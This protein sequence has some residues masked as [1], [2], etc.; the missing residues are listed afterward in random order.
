MK[1]SVLS[2]LALAPIQWLR[3]IRGFRLVYTPPC[4]LLFYLPPS[5]G[6]FWEP[7]TCEKG[8]QEA[9]LFRELSFAK[10]QIQLRFANNSESLNTLN[11]EIAAS[12][13]DAKLKQL[14][15]EQADDL[16][17]NNHEIIKILWLNAESAPQW[18]APTSNTKSD[19]FSKTLKDTAINE[20]LAT[21]IELSRVT[22]RTAF[23]KFIT[24]NSPEIDSNN[25]D[26]RTVFWQVAPNIVGG[27]TVGFLAALY[28]TQGILE[29]IP[30]E[31]KA[32][33]R[34]TLLTDGDRVLSISSDRGTPKRA[35]STQTSLDMGVLNP[36]LALR[37]D[38]YPLPTNLTFRMLIGVVLGLSAFVIW[39]LWSVLKQMQV[40]QEAEASLRSETSFRNAMENSTPVGI[41]AHDMQKR[42]TY[43]NRAFCE[44]TGWSAH[45]LIGLAPPF[46]FWPAEKHDEM[47]EKMNRALKPDV[48][49][50][51]GIEGF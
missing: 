8:Q 50:K 5:W 42:I 30:N 47:V 26:G 7:C 32:F 19:R 40:R 24:V 6:L 17:L 38:T 14:I 20:G 49:P 31:L 39:S 44:M 23:S 15:R 36:N 34:F 22:G 4:W 28:T 25:M 10:Q 45:E 41:R 9:A 37:I 27:Q 13:E 51:S 21:A 43:V 11:R 48:S 18:V 29:I 33:Y 3:K 46:P 35:F 12:S 1:S 16:I 2:K